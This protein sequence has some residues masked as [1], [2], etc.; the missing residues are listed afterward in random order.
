MTGAIRLGIFDIG[1]DQMEQFLTFTGATNAT[2]TMARVHDYAH[3][4]CPELEDFGDCSVV[5][6]N[7]AAGY[8]RVDWFTPDGLRTWGMAAPPYSALTTLSSCARTLISR[9][10]SRART[11]FIL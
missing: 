7:Q 5:G 3:P 8:F 6:D 11:T 9:P 4:E 10:L 1:S 2:I